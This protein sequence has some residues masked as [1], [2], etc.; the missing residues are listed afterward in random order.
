M[1]RPG[2]SLNQCLWYPGLSGYASLWTNEPNGMRL[3][4]FTSDASNSSESAVLPPTSTGSIPSSVC[5]S[6]CLWFF[7]I[8]H[9]LPTLPRDLLLPQ[10]LS[11]V[12]LTGVPRDGAHKPVARLPLSRRQ[13][14]ERELGPLPPLGVGRGWGPRL[15]HCW[16]RVAADIPEP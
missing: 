14:I 3:S 15:G 12:H 16:R 2:L 9:S 7:D 11:H 6:A 4:S 10:V 5:T 13:V 1:M 8:S